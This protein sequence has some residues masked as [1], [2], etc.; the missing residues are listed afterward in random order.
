MSSNAAN[1]V[2]ADLAWENNY[3]SLANEPDELSFPTDV[4][5]GFY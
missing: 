4:F 2:F 3:D 5:T 1:K